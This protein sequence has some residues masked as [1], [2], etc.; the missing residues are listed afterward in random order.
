M[1]TTRRRRTE[2]ERV[3]RE[4]GK[5]IGAQ[6]WEVDSDVHGQFT[7]MAK[8]HLAAVKR[9]R[10]RTVG[11]VAVENGPGNL[12]CAGLHLREGVEEHCANGGY[13]VARVVLV[14]R[15]PAKT[16]RGKK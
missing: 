13:M 6:P 14:P 2:V 9:A 15:S 12:C 3:A 7:K 10:G 8:W 11:Y 5:L 1:K 4:L 16:R